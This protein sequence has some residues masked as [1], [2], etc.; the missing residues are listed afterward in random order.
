MIYLKNVAGVLSC[1]LTDKS[2]ESAA[3]GDVLLTVEGK[4]AIT[5]KTFNDF[6]EHYTCQ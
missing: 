2:L 5:T 4:P 1:D 3:P 6:F